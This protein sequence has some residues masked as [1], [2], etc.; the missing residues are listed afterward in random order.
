MSERISASKARLIGEVVLVLV[1]F[2]ATMLIGLFLVLFL[3]GIFYPEIL[4]GINPETGEGAELLNMVGY[5]VAVV[6]MLVLVHFLLKF[7]GLSWKNIG[8]TRP[9]NWLKTIGW[10]LAVTVAAMAMG[11]AVGLVMESLGH[12]Q[13]LTTFN[14][15]E[16]NFLA[17]LFMATIISWFA[18]ALGEEVIFRG[19]VMGNLAEAFGGE[20][21]AWMLAALLQAFI[22]GAFHLYQ[23][24][25]G[26]VAAGMIAVVFGLAYY[27]LKN[28][29]PVIIAH[30]L[31]DT[32]GMTLFYFG[33]SDLV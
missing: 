30:G 20:K 31:I 29:W 32:Y 3:A 26:G 8:L 11:Y 12:E 18:A 4:E 23:D 7:R 24:L 6:L 10:G 9:G 13:D 17:Y 27:W 1:A 25:A 16:G 5:S 28:L 14:F 15:I 21:A 2:L 22:F 19:V 33:F